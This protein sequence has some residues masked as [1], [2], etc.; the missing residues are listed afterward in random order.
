MTHRLVHAIAVAVAV[1][2]VGTGCSSGSSNAGTNGDGP[3]VIGMTIPLT[4][5]AASYGA[6]LK[7]AVELWAKDVNGGGGLL[8]RQVKLD[9]RDDAGDPTVAVTQ[10]Q[11][12]VDGD[13]E[14]LMGMFGSA[15]TEKVS[16]IAERRKKLFITAIA[17][18]EA[19]YQR[20]YKYLLMGLPFPAGYGYDELEHMIDAVPQSD[21]PKTFASVAADTPASIPEAKRGAAALERA[22]LKEVFSDTY[23]ADATD[24]SPIVARMKDSNPDVVLTS[25]GNVTQDASFWRALAD[26]GLKPRFKFDNPQGLDLPS[27]G[28]KDEANGITFP[29]YFDPKLDFP[30]TKKFVEG[31]KKLTNGAAPD[32]VGA[33]AYSSMQLLQAG[34]EGAKSTDQSAARE[35]L[36]KNTVETIS[37]QVKFEKNGIRTGSAKLFTQWQDGKAV[38]VWPKELAT[39]DWQY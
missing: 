31:Y 36:A 17:A 4:G 33:I 24:L 19:L 22:G 29:N 20:G 35:F 30:G 14:Y 16:T 18:S 5:P 13:A 26:A 23:P 28:L 34:V 10:Y 3:I 1:C 2:L 9:I 12:M 6:K 7:P 27:V 32:W 39:S 38:I 8:G 25:A 15:V 11:Q 37:G 21:R